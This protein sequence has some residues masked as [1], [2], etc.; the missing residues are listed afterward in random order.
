MQVGAS[1]GA[2]TEVSSHALS[3][4]TR[5][6][7]RGQAGL[8]DGRTNRGDGL[9]YGWPEMTLPTAAAATGNQTVYRCEKCGMTYSEA[10]AKK[11]NY[12][13]PMDGGRLACPRVKAGM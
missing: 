2:W 13:D 11:H 5:V 12:L 9:G 10:D 4:G 3:A 1:D 7:T 6:V 8:T